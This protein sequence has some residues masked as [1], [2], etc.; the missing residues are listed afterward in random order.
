MF[1]IMNSTTGKIIG[2]FVCAL[3]TLGAMNDIRAIINREYGYSY[4][5]IWST[6]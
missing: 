5:V 6:K 1:E 3:P 4:S 2:S